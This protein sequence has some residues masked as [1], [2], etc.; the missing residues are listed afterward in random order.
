VLLKTRLKKAIERMA[1]HT[2]GPFRH[3]FVK[4]T[5]HAM[6]VVEGTFYL[7]PGATYDDVAEILDAWS[8]DDGITRLIGERRTARIQV[9]YHQSRGRQGEYTLAEIG[10]WDFALGRAIERVD[11]RDGDRDALVERYGVDGSKGTSAI[12]RLYVWFGEDL[13]DVSGLDF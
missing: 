6:W 13:R 7:P 11:V 5:R 3:E 4:A 1:R 2:G 8:E 12:S 10:S 9:A